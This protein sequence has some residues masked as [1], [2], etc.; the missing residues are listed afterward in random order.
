M[1]LIDKLRHQ[2]YG[3]PPDFVPPG[4]DPAMIGAYRKFADG[5]L[6][7]LREHQDIP[8]I[9]V[10]NVAEYFYSNYDSAGWHWRDSFP[11]IAPP[12]FRCWLE[13]RLTRQMYSGAGKDARC[14]VLVYGVDSKS[15]GRQALEDQLG[16][17]LRDNGRWVL[18]MTVYG[19]TDPGQVPT[20][21]PLG[22][23][24]VVV[25]EGGGAI[26]WYLSNASYHTDKARAMMEESAYRLVPVL[27]AISFMHCKNVK[28]V[29]EQVPEKLAK[30][31][32][33]RHGYRPTPWHTL[34]I[35]PLKEVLRKQGQADKTGLKKAL[36]ICRGHFARFG[37]DG[38]GLLFGKYSGSFF[39]PQHVKGKRQTKEEKPPLR[40]IEIKL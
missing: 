31:T 36:H 34:V 2:G 22:S 8:V 38:R 27:L 17:E 1:K 6:A 14:G 28:T 18:M 19:D 21:P 32:L 35:E 30:R 20:A 9:V 5:L 25:D 4:V 39:I 15:Y 23:Y 26:I 7:D 11:N 24:T 13:Y 37:V 40:E 33:E 3:L 12:F 29:K 10:D 16:V